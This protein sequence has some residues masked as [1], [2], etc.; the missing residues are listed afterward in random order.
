[1]T[2]SR[3]LALGYASAFAATA[4]T[5]E[6]SF[7]SAAKDARAMLMGAAN[8]AISTE[9]RFYAPLVHRDEAAPHSAFLSIRSADTAWM[10]IDAMDEG[11]YRRASG[12]YASRGYRLR[13]IGAFQTRKGVRYAAIWQYASG[14]ALETRHAMTRAQFEQ[15]S[16]EHAARGLRL[17]HVDACAT[18]SG[19]RFAAIWE[20]DGGAAQETFAALSGAELK[21]KSAALAAEGFRPRVLSGYAAGGASHYAAVFERNSAVAWDADHAMTASAF[22]EK[23]RAMRGRGYLLTAASGHVLNGRTVFSGVWEKA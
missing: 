10:A 14:P 11:A 19:V 8:T 9:Q 23:S 3:R 13:R 21:E 12:K 1:M 2:F 17:S 16:R 15:V 7:A 4:G 18:H 5:T 6:L 20:R 22:A